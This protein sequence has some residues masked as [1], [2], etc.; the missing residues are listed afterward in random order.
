[1]SL[2]F[3][4]VPVDHEFLGD[5]LA[6][7][8]IDVRMEDPPVIVNLR[9]FDQIS[10][11][12]VYVGSELKLSENSLG[13]FTVELN[14]DVVASNLVGIVDKKAAVL[15]GEVAVGLYDFGLYPLEEA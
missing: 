9:T 7:E 11:V 4:R 10:G 8:D 3:R 5:D 15:V 2:L 14:D 6:S 12:D 1:M 13:G